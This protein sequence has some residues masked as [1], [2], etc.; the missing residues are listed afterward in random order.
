MNERI[1]EL[2]NEVGISVEYLTITKQMELLEKFAELI[3]RECADVLDK[4]IAPPNHPMNSLGYELKQHFGIKQMKKYTNRH[5]DSYYFEPI[6]NDKLKFV[7]ESRSMEYIRFGGKDN[8]L[9]YNDLGFFDPS[10]GPFIKI[11][12]TIQG[13]K[14]TKIS[15]TGDG[16]ILEVESLP[17]ESK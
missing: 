16:I 4:Q 7:M 14:V 15:S 12:T 6:S 9:D 3:V 10:G 8:T 1:R 13:R 11:G 5:G 17:S 2:A